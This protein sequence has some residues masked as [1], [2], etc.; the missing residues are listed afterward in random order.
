MDDCNFL[1]TFNNKQVELPF[2]FPFFFFKPFMYRL[3]YARLH[4]INISDYLRSKSIPEMLMEST[5]F[6]VVC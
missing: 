6:Q 5:V 3:C 2:N 1:I 4:E